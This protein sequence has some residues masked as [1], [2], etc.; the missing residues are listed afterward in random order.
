MMHCCQP[1]KST[2]APACSP[3][4]ASQQ[5]YGLQLRTGQPGSM[6]ARQPAA[7]SSDCQRRVSSHV[8]SRSTESPD[9]SSCHKPCCWQSQRTSVTSQA[10]G[11]AGR[12]RRR[13]AGGACHCRNRHQ[14]CAEW[15]KTHQSFNIHACRRAWV[16]PCG[17][18]AAPQ[19][20][21][22]HADVR[23]TAGPA[24]SW[25]RSQCGQQQPHQHAANLS[26]R[27]PQ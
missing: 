1:T 3:E 24:A 12:I 21:R 8:N 6:A 15:C 17:N 11:V 19:P 22:A 14:S 16:I 26:G 20:A 2:G 5:P 25:Q 4:A 9:V 7:C 23:T 13:I 18:H 27:E 10:T